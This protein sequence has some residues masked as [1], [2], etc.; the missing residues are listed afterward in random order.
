M[1]IMEFEVITGGINIF[2]ETC[3]ILERDSAIIFLAD[4]F[5][6][7]LEHLIDDNYEWPSFNRVVDDSLG[8]IIKRRDIF[9]HQKHI[10]S[11]KLDTGKNIVLKANERVQGLNKDKQKITGGTS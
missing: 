2:A 6:K 8:Q 9:L 10:S 7:R 11:T 5:F 3:Y 1:T 4:E